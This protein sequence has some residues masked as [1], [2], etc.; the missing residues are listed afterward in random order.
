MATRQMLPTSAAAMFLG[1][2]AETLRSWRR[3]GIGPPFCRYPGGHVRHG[4]GT[5]YWEQKQ[6]GCIYYPIESLFAF[7]ER[8]TVQEGR[9]PRP[10]PGRLPGSEKP[11]SA[12][13]TARPRADR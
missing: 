4:A 13:P 7:I 9:L 12:K 2:T 10:F 11:R 1:V 3:R 5:H 6:H 8:L